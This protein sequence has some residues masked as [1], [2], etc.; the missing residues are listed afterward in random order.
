[1]KLTVIAVGKLRDAWAESGCT[2]YVKRL[3]GRF[4]LD[5]IEL[6]ESQPILP[7]VPER[8]KL[9]ALDERGVELTSQELA[10][11]FGAAMRISEPG[12]AFVIGGADGLSDEVLQAAHFRWSLGKLTLPHRLCRIILLEQLYRASTILRGE[13]YHRP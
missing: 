11:K 2:E 10:D 1:V 4:A 13:P 9:W 8:L 3:R 12:F 5:L 6:K 7:R